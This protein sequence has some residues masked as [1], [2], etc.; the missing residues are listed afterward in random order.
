MNE[1]F[2]KYSGQNKMNLIW[3]LLTEEREGMKRNTEL[4]MERGNE[5]LTFE[6]LEQSKYLLDL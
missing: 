6:E 5:N 3:M 2:M 1:V 4:G